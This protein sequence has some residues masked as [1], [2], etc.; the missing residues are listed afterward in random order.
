MAGTGGAEIIGVTPGSIGAELELEPG[1]RLLR[2]NGRDLPDYIEYLMVSSE[3][4][5][6]LEVLKPS[7]EL[8]LVEIEKESDEGLGLTFAEAV[9]DGIRPCRNH[10]L[11]C[12][13]HQLPA[14]QRPTLYIQ[15]DD[16]RLSFLQG[17]YITLT[18]LTENDW[19]RI[20]EYHL[21]P[22]Y[23]SVHAT[24]PDVRCKILGSKKAGEILGQLERLAGAG[25]TVHTQAVLC[26]GINDGKVLERTIA[27]L[28]QLHPNV[29]S[30]ALVPV[31]LT[32]HR[33]GLFPLH[34]FT[35]AE[36][37]SV[38]DKV[39]HYQ[40]SYLQ[41]LKT[42]FVYAADEW[43]LISGRPIPSEAEYED[44]LQLDN[45]VGL[46]RRFLSDTEDC[47]PEVI[48]ILANQPRHRV[49]VTGIAAGR[50]WGEISTRLRTMAPNLRLDIL[51]VENH[52]FGPSVTVTGLL[53]GRDIAEAIKAHQGGDDALYLL[54]DITLRQGEEVFLDGMALPELM[55]ACFPKQVRVVPASA[56]EWWAWFGNKEE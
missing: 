17:A 24:D 38:L 31:G 34:N 41:S 5:L 49:I 48:D 12:F 40:K 6:T 8:F 10:C 39:E 11:F 21:S 22:L 44:F 36:A 13:V 50:L 23:V 18:N 35:A 30:L 42:R 14:G 54:P 53:S 15:D 25:I 29:A 47:L 4:V 28:A 45:G 46:I 1:D 9:F 27:D 32:G 26:P 55:E 52:F 20:E 7:G 19:K 2:V 33:D 3:D 37:G 51:Q 43:Y 16:Y 56:F